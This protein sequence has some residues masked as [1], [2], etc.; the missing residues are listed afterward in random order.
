MNNVEE[1][2]PPNEETPRPQDV[3]RIGILLEGGMAVLAGV[4]G[5]MVGFDPTETI[6][7]EYDALADHAR[8]IGWGL[9]AVAPL[10]V[11]VWLIDNYPI[12][13]LRE[14]N[15]LVDERVRPM[16]AGLTAEQLALLATTAGI[17]EEVLFRGLLQAGLTEWIGP[18]L[19]MW[20]A[21][22]AA[23][24]VFGLCH[25]ISAAYF[26]LTALIGVY[27]GAL[28]LWTGNLLAP[29][30]THAVYDFFA[31][32]YLLRWKSAPKP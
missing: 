20:I 29:I 30:T 8:A 4:I 6:R 12:G 26:L 13:R 32:L 1:P 11:W 2:R 10:A 18:P 27:L 25:Y 9:A 21:L 23:S 24:V 28:F 31:L 5:W 17:G 16:F 15:R 7:L 19:G 14:F 3:F 22:A